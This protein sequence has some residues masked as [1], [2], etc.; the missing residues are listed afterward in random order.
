MEIFSNLHWLEAGYANVYLYVEETGLTLVDTGIPGRE[1]KILAYIRETLSLKPEAL[2]RILITHADW[3]HAGSA[4]ALHEA[5]GAT[6]FAGEETAEY[7]QRGKSPPHMPRPVQFFVDRFVGFTPLPEASLTVV[8]DGDTLPF[9]GG[10]GVFFTPG[11]TPD[12]HAFYSAETGIIFAGD[13]LGTRSGKLGLS[14]EFITADTVAARQSA[15]RLLA[16][17]PAVFACGHGEPLKGHT[18]RD[19]MTVLQNL[20]E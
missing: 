2:R 20:K 16:L 6:I 14:A 19:L 9:C 1:E 18:L 7:L 11:H 17:S 5:T 10:L 15:R 8:A 13:S 4:Q 12:H 3:D